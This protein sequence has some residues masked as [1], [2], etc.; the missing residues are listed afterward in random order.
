[1]SSGFVYIRC[2]TAY[3]NACKLGITSNL[4]ERDSLYSTGE[5]RRG[6]FVKMLE[7]HHVSAKIVETVLQKEFKSHHVYFD[8]GTEFFDQAIIP[9]IEPFLTEIGIDYVSISQND[10]NRMKRKNRLKKLLKRIKPKSLLI[11]LKKSVPEK[12]ASFQPREDQLESIHLTCQHFQKKSKG[13]LVL[14]CGVGKTLISL[15]STKQLNCNKI[16]I[17]VPNKLLLQQWREK[18]ELI[19]PKHC[20][21][22]VASGTKIEDIVSTFSSNSFIIIT[23]YSSAFK[24]LTATEVNDIMFDMKILDEAHHLTSF[25]LN[26]E[27]ESKEFVKILRVVSSKQLSLTATLK[28]IEVDGTISNRDVAYFGEIIQKRSLLWAITQNIICDYV[29]QTIYTQ[30]EK[31]T[32][33]FDYFEVY[34]DVERRLFLSAFTALKSLYENHSHHLLVYTNNMTHAAKVVHYMHLL[35]NLKVFQFNE[36]AINCYNSNLSLKTQKIVLHQFERSKKGVISCVYCL[37]E[38]WDFPLLD[39]VVFAENMSSTIRIVQS[40]LRASRLN[41]MEPNKKAKIILPILCTDD[42]LYSNDNTDLKKVKTIIQQLGQEDETVIQ[43]MESFALLS[44]DTKNKKKPENGTNVIEISNFGECDDEFTN[45]LKLKTISRYAT[46]VTY[47]KAVEIIKSK[48]I[49]NKEDYFSL[50]QKDFRLP[51]DPVS[52][53]QKFISWTDYL[54]IERKFYLKEEAMTKIQFLISS[55]TIS[56]F[57][58]DYN[59]LC[60]KICTLDPMFPPFDLWTDYYEVPNLSVM[61]QS[62]KKFNFKI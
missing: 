36:I 18:V 28:Y 58:L 31:L 24:V 39:G 2:H 60:K 33:F 32:S 44:D 37:G 35:T 62:R 22:C 30:E 45:T 7:I 47:E 17:G 3:E 4:V 13:L 54:G 56:Q 43:K 14:T 61:F 5:V 46:S 51:K 26:F 19:F 57:T 38:G 21:L 16:L 15:W 11:A 48:N 6:T 52:V 55:N 25:S 50:C 49:Q 42:W 12:P 23:T 9:L 20:I 53:F 1:M 29:I 34:T 59:N 40:L 41:K 8:A 27:E 10:F